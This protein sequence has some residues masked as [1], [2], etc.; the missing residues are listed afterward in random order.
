MD[1][2]VVAVGHMKHGVLCHATQH[3]RRMARHRLQEI[4]FLVGSDGDNKPPEGFAP[5]SAPKVCIP[6]S[7]NIDVGTKSAANAHLG[8]GHSHASFAAIVG[9]PDSPLLYGSGELTVRCEVFFGVGEQRDLPTY[10]GC[11]TGFGQHERQ[12]TGA[13]F[14]F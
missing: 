1:D 8:H 10:P 9:G 13:Q 3:R 7:I 4:G 12:F 2:G 14:I 5:Q 6:S 11:F